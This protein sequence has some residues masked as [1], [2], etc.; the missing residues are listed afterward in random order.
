VNAA[1]GMI[2][3][4]CS[5]IAHVPN[6]YFT[7]GGDGLFAGAHVDHWAVTGGVGPYAN[8]RGQIAVTNN[9]NGSSSAVVTLSS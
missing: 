6:G 2:D 8:D 3:G 9:K 1:T 5:A 7:F 4:V